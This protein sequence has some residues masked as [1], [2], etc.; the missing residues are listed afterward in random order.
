VNAPD[1]TG[2]EIRLERVDRLRHQVVIANGEPLHA[3]VFNV[4]SSASRKRFIKE[5]VAR[6]PAVTEDWLDRELIRLSARPEPGNAVGVTGVTNGGGEEPWPDPVDGAKLLD[7][8]CGV[9]RMYMVLT[10]HEADVLALWLAH[11]YAP[12]VGTGFTPYIWISSPVRECGKSTLLD[13]LSHLAYRAQKTEGI[14][15]AALYRKIHRDAPTM[16]LDE[17]DTRL[18]GDGGENLR[19][20]LNSGF[21]R[22]SKVTICVGDEHEATDF[23]TFC[24]KVLA[25]IGRLWDTVA[26]RSIPVRLRRAGKAELKAL[27]KL[28]GD[29]A[30]GE[31]LPYRRR[32]L[33]L[34]ADIRDELAEADP[35][36]P[37]ELGARQGDIWRPLL[38]IA[39]AVG[40][41]WPTRARNAA[42]AVHKETGDEGDNGLLLLEDLRGLFARKGADALFS[43]SIIEELVGME[44]RPWPEYRADKAITKNG[45]ASLLRR[46]DV[47]PLTV[48]VGTLTAKGYRLADLAPVFEVYLPTP[49]RTVTTVTLPENQGQSARDT[50]VTGGDTAPTHFPGVTDGVTTVTPV[51]NASCHGG[52]HRNPSSVTDVTVRSDTAGGAIPTGPN[53]PTPGVCSQ[54]KRPSGSMYSHTCRECADR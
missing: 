2:L 28:R 48:R 6:V 42:V 38:A 8:L 34:V 44:G 39:D 50:L 24:P 12:D 52:N 40:G 9:I 36:V 47:R 53:A 22:G 18:R 33:R 49:E 13:V 21:Q 7:D 14:T 23:N 15:A 1:E 29:R 11:T 19:G 37:D 46:F 26:S 10:T 4:A 27:K 25:G 30:A 43:E 41:D 54:C 31:C 17:L 32:L 35:N 45:L 20:V 3:D 5:A 16:L 51:K